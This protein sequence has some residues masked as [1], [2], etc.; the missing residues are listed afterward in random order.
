VVEEAFDIG[1]NN[2]AATATVDIPAQSL[3]RVVAALARAKTVRK[4]VKLLLVDSLKHLHH[5]ALHQFT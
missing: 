5:A 2:P 3:E 1:L 4:R